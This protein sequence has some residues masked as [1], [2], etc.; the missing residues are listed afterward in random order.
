MEILE[1][2]FIDMRYFIGLGLRLYSIFFLKYFG[3]ICPQYSY[4][5]NSIKSPYNYKTNGA[6]QIFDIKSPYHLDNF[7]ENLFNSL[8][9]LINFYNKDFSKYVLCITDIICAILILYYLMIQPSR[10]KN[11]NERA[12][13]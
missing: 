5:T 3:N 10:L 1:I 6:I 2:F 9:Y 7:H 4:L 8:F 11:R 12:T 13:S